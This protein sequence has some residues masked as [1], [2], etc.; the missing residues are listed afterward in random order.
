MLTLAAEDGDFTLDRVTSRNNGLVGGWYIA[1]GG[2]SYAVV[3]FLADGTYF[4]VEDG[5]TGK[6]GRTGVERGTYKW[7]PVSKSFTRRLLIDTNGTWG[8]S[9]N[10]KRS[11]TISG[12]KLNLTVQ[13][14]GKYTLSRVVASK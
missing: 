5:K 10:R 13:G 9:D 12:N 7:S 11:I 8:F 4:M 14:E 6:G 3:T 2:G 1:T